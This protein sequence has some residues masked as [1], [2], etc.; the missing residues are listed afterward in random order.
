MIHFIDD[1]YKNIQCVDNVNEQNI[2]TYFIDKH[3]QPKE[4]LNKLLS[5]I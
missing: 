1:S 4:H 2:R 3:K 5:K